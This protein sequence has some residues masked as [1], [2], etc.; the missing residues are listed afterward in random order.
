MLFA[1][2]GLNGYIRFIITISL[3][4]LLK[5]KKD[6]FIKYIYYIFGL[7]VMLFFLT[8]GFDPIWGKL[9][10]YV[11]KDNTLTTQD[12]LSLHFFSVMQTV[13]EAGKIPFETFANRISGHTITFFISTIG[14]I[15]MVYKKPFM[16][17]GL[18]MIGLGF[19]AYIGG[20]KFTIYAVPVLA[21]GVAFLIVELSNKLKTNL[22]KYSLMT[23]LTLMILYPNV[24]HIINYKVNT[25]FLKDEVVVL[26]RLR[27][28]SSRKD[29]VVSWWD[30]G[31][32]IRYYSNVRTLADGNKHTGDVNFPISYILTHSQEE[33]SK[34]LRLDV[35]Y[36]EES[37]KISE[38]NKDRSEKERIKRLNN[39]AQM[40]LDYGFKDTND[41]LT[42]LQTDIKLPKKTRD[43]YLYL[44]NR[45]IN[46]YPT[47]TLFSNL[48]LMT[49]KKWSKHFMFSSHRYSQDKDF[50][51]LGHGFKIDKRT[52]QIVM[53][54]KTIPTK[55]YVKVTIDNTGETKRLMKE[56]NPNGFLNIIYVPNSKVFFVVDDTVY[57][58]LY[59]Q[60]AILGNYDK[61][62]FEPTILSP[63]TKV[64]KL[65]I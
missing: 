12:E 39:I 3:F 42:S 50:I 20:L 41:F 33:A 14:Y 47:I 35:E 55:R 51:L 25:V 5:F 6:F 60:L 15:W 58:S 7:A 30:Y 24:R 16:I 2:I 65:K 59:F 48:D 44:P 4:I 11:F 28:I 54:K 52:L 63:L 23:I 32:P 61:E 21:L 1:M 46:I 37:F 57:N 34:M 19:M 40:T 49:G 64:Y 45:L 18:P 38:L 31:Y 10:I 29:Y 13:R 56:T 9:S 43:I 8:G 26:D 53:N 17:L 36:T 27:Q 22:A 62:L